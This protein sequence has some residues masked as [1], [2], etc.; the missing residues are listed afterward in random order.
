MKHIFNKKQLFDIFITILIILFSCLIIYHLY[1]ATKPNKNNGNY[2]KSTII[3]GFTLGKITLQE[4]ISCD[5][6][7]NNTNNNTNT[8][9]NFTNNLCNALIIDISNILKKSY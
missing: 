2:S 3:E 4:N 7:N 1:L 9:N 8:N 5:N 6:N